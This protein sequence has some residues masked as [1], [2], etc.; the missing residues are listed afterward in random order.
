[1]SYFIHGGD[2]YRNKV[3]MDFSV[4]I[5]PLGVPDCVMHAMTE[6]LLHVGK[7]PD[8]QSGMLRKSCAEMLHVKEDTIL[9]GNGSSELLMAIAHALRPDKIMIPVP[10]YSG[11][12]YAFTGVCNEIVYYPMREENGYCLTEDFPG[13]LDES[14]GCLLIANPNNPV[15]ATINRE[16]LFRIIGKCAEKGIQVILDECFIEF[17]EEESAVLKAEEYPNLIILRSFTKIFAIPSVRIGY[18]ICSGQKTIEKVA[19]H[20]PEWNVSGIAQRAGLECMRRGDYV[21]KSR[22]YVKKERQLL[23]VEL[24]QLGITVYDS[25]ADFL[26]LYTDKPLY[27]LLLQQGILIRDCSNFRGLGAGYYRI[28]VRTH[29]ENR[30][31]MKALQVIYGN[32]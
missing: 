11:Y 25:E 14:I 12:E 5:N 22:E 26:L 3:N 15:G 7:Y 1:M 30:E 23:S 13:K 20:L 21:E 6:A 32:N 10:S 24:R 17:T 18:M 16:L 31:L 4:N 8:I 9:F 2:V 19:S 28:A 27:G 29:E